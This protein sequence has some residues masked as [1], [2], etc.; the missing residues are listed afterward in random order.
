MNGESSKRRKD[1]FRLVECSDAF[2]CFVAD[3]DSRISGF[4]I[5]EDLGDGVSSYVVQI[6]VT[7]RRMGIGR[8]LI[9]KV[10]EAAGKGGHISLCVNTDNDDS[11]RFFEAMGF[12]RS[13]QTEGYRKDQNKHWYQIDL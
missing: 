6:N 3:D 1:K 11:I 7:E 13:G 12:R 2:T 4:V 10:F 8:K 9:Q 5:V